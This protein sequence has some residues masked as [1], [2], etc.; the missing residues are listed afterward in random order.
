MATSPKSSV[1]SKT[2]AGPETVARERRVFKIFIRGPIEKVW[3]EITKTDEAQ[4]CFYNAWLNTTGLRVGAPVQMRTKSG[5]FALVVGE[6]TEFDPPHRY[7]HTFRFTTEDDPPCLVVYDLKSVTNGTEFT[8]TVENVPVG[9]K[10][11][12]AMTSGGTT[13]VTLLKAIVETG[14]PPLGTRIQYAL[15]G[16]MEGVLPK[17]ARSENWPL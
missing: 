13:I 11:D 4:G 16:A 1:E 2:G 5:R 6:V 12:K 9:T 14:K 3:H 8:L 7:A 15:M 10:T 17:Q